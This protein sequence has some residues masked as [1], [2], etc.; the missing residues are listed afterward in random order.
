MEWVAILNPYHDWS[1]L[2]DLAVDMWR[3]KECIVDAGSCGDYIYVHF[4]NK[5]SQRAFE[6]LLRESN[7]NFAHCDR[8]RFIDT[9]SGVFEVQYAPS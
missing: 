4:S 3:R 1:K 7:I 8:S 9:Y 2:S 6:S 5:E